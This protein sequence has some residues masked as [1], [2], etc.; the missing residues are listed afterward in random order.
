MTTIEKNEP[1]SHTSKIKN[2][3]AMGQIKPGQSGIYLGRAILAH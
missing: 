1:Y 2:K 3:R